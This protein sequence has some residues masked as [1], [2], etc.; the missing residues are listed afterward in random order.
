MHLSETT[1]AAVTGAGSGIGRALAL[2]LAARGA[3]LALADVNADALHETALLARPFG[4]RVSVHPLDVSREAEVA[5]YAAAAVSAHGRVNLL[6]NNAGVAL[7]GTFEELS[8]GDLEWIMGINFWGG[9][10]GCRHFLPFLRAA[11]P[12]RIVNV[13]SVFGL[14]GPP[15]QTGYAA[16]KFAV[17]GFSEALRH[18]LRGSGVGLSVVHPGGIRTAIARRARP[19]SL[20]ARP[21]EEL[22]RGLADFERRLVTSPQ[23]AAARILRGIERDEGR[24]LI[25]TDATI[26]DVLQRLFPARYMAA[27]ER[28]T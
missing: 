27:L 23:A 15:E 25:G 18:E 11:A 13:S 2:R 14:I 1:V 28:V 4:H 3:A 9:V 19:G 20:T 7:G 17:R 26:I 16:S 22:E 24:I 5:D 12:A 8:Q 21:R 10:Y 6:V